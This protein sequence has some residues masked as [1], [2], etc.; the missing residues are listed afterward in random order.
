VI[1][2][3]DK[4]HGRNEP[5][6]APAMDAEGEKLHALSWLFVLIA[7]L[8]NLIGPILLLLVAGRLSKDDGWQ[9]LIALI[10]A[11]ILSAYALFYTSTFRFWVGSGELI[12]KEGLF[13]RTL[14]HVPFSR[15][16]NIARRQSVLHRLFG[17]VELSLESGAGAKPEAKMTVL[18]LARAN[19]LEQQIRGLTQHAQ[20][21]TEAAAA[22]QNAPPN[23]ETLVH[24]VGIDELL[25]LGLI[26]NRGMVLI[27]GAFYFLS[28]TKLFS[29]ERGARQSIFNNITHWLQA[30]VGVAHGPLFW[31]LTGLVWLLLI[32]LVVRLASVLLAIITFHDFKLFA[33]GTRLRVEHG[34]GT[35]QGGSTTVQRIVCV[36]V[37]DGLLYRWFNRQTVEVILPGNSHDG[38]KKARGMRYLSPVAPPETACELVMLGTGVALDQ[39]VLEPLHP[40]AWKRM[41]KWPVLI[42]GA[43]AL[44]LS[45]FLALHRHGYAALALIALYAGFFVW[46]VYAYRRTAASSGFALTPSHCIIRSGYFNQCTHIVP[47]REVQNV[48][49]SQSPFDRRSTMANV[50]LD[51]SAGSALEAPQATVRYLPFKVACALA[52]SLRET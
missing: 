11:V 49:L 25:R 47:R 19:L 15:I 14:R 34:L 33:H 2:P 10:V 48:T 35:R 6:A 3:R 45:V 39:L 42:V 12:V 17:V 24:H 21:A 50:T 41:V 26:S 23:V 1:E 28:Q 18:P 44:A 22:S 9:A 52:A 40:R 29:S 43:Q 16:Q 27:G 31:T 32:V 5:T 36:L 8:L 51:L 7:Q 30:T 20:P 37:R 13:N 46:M 38:G 4:R